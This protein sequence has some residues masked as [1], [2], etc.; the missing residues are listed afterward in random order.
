MINTTIPFTSQ[1]VVDLIRQTDLLSTDEKQKL[2]DFMPNFSQEERNLLGSQI[3]DYEQKKQ[4][5]LRDAEERK[6]KI[7]E[8]YYKQ[9]ENLHQEEQKRLRAEIRRKEE[10]DHH[11]SEEEADK[12]MQLM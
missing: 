11:Q 2:V 4:E 8:D 6:H 10:E 9:I 5:I 12:L 1:Y 3:V 7:E